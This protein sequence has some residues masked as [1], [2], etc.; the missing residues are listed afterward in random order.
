[1]MNLAMLG[2]FAG[3]IGL[4]LLGMSLMTD[5]LKLA[6]GPSLERILAQ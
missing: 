6:A 5:G 1:M 4:F 2:S 3:G